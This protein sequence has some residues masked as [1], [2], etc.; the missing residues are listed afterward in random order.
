MLNFFIFASVT[1]VGHES[2]KKRANQDKD[3]NDTTCITDTDIFILGG[4]LAYMC[5]YFA[6]S[7]YHQVFFGIPLF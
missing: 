4:F 5:V 3:E 2:I 6:R 1:L 7:Y